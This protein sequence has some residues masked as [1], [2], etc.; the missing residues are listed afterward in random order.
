[1]KVSVVIPVF[2]EVR[3]VGQVIERVRSVPMDKEVIVIDDGSDD[4]TRDVLGEYADVEG[5]R[6]HLAA[7]NR[8]KGAALRIGF[9][10][11]RGDIV[12]V[13]D[14]DL[15]VD[16]ADHP[17]LCAPIEE[18]RA[19]V[20]LGSRFTEGR[21]GPWLSYAGNRG[22]T[23]LTNLLFGAHLSDMETCFKVFRST[24]L[25]TLRLRANHFDIEP[26][27]VA[28]FLKGGWRLVEVPVSY[29]PRTVD[30]GKKLRV[31]DG[32]DAVA[33]LLGCRFLR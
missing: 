10:M 6:V 11:V 23:G 19:D 14:A 20:V 2:N 31:R 5:V 33:M 30:A 15:E 1:M 25:P 18:D 9:G 3:T 26:E 21:R 24:I 28:S 32:L 7:A 8:G 29:A 13:Q 12:L 17:R 4:G 22:L 27:L 16:P